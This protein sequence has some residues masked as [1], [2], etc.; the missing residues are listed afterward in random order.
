MLAV[1]HSNS[2]NM[3]YGPANSQMHMLGERKQEIG[4]L[5]PRRQLDT[6]IRNRTLPIA[7][8]TMTRCLPAPS[9]AAKTD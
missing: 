5:L 4:N 3:R 2:G 9:D 6:Q 7:D 8:A 1:G